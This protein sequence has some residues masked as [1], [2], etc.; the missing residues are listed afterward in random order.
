MRSI[1]ILPITPTSIALDATAHLFDK[2]RQFYGQ[3]SQSEV[4]QQFLLD[5][6]SREES[7]ILLATVDGQAVGF[8]QLYRSFSSLACSH[9]MTLNDLFVSS[10]CRS[11]GVG[12]RLIEAAIRYAS[13]C[14]VESIQLE[15]AHDNTG[16][17]RLYERLG[18]ERAIGFLN[19]TLSCGARQTGAQ[20]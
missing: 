12:S 1:D 16:A 7:V 20:A 3:P 14:G 10:G 19:Y 13:D 17:Q 8:V 5:R 11:W 2:Y 18:F 6:L 15:T 9:T 4:C